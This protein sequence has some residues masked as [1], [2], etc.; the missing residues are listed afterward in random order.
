MNAGGDEVVPRGAQI[1]GVVQGSQRSAYVG[2]HP[3]L[4]LQVV[5]L[6][7]EGGPPS[8]VPIEVAQSPVE[9]SS[10][11]AREIVGALGGAGVGAAIGVGFD[12]QSAGVVVG[13]TFLGLG[14]GAL[15]GYLFSP[16]DAILPVGSVVTLRVTRDIRFEKPVASR[17]PSS[18]GAT[19]HWRPVESPVQVQTLSKPAQ[20][21]TPTKPAEVPIL[22]APPP[23]LIKPVD[24]PAPRGP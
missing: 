24:A 7:S 14:L 11:T 1:D 4:N 10:A 9:M 23:P 13:T 17:E 22:R 8:R 19:A 15:L 6:E 18:T 5:G 16:R 20:V 12:R 21:Q 3:G 2:E